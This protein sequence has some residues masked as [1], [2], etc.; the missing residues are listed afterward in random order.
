M[1]GVAEQCRRALQACATGQGR[2]DFVAAIRKYLRENP[3]RRDERSN[4]TLYNVLSVNASAS[5]KLLFGR[6]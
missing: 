4:G 1:I 3:N 2:A 5:A 6:S